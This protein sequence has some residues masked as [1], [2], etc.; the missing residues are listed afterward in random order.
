MGR[1]PNGAEA[2]HVQEHSR[3]GVTMTGSSGDGA[4]AEVCWVKGKV[5]SASAGTARAQ[6]RSRSLAMSVGRV[7]DMGAGAFVPVAARPFA[8][9]CALRRRRRVRGPFGHAVGGGAF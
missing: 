9:F 3:H 4:G 7:F 1:T 5:P 6:A 2:A 8:A